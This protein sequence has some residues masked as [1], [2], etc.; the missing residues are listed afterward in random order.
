MKVQLEDAKD[1]IKD[2]EEALEIEKRNIES[3]KAELKETREARDSLMAHN[4]QLKFTI[5]QAESAVKQD[6]IEVSVCILY[7]YTS[8][9]YFTEGTKEIRFFPPIGVSTTWEI[10]EKKLPREGKSVKTTENVS[11]SMPASCLFAN[12][13]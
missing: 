2:L 4:S 10:R 6:N 9:V 1:T 8:A 3:L 12:C 13:Q 5:A 11:G 7:R